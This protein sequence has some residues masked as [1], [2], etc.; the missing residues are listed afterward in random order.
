MGRIISLPQLNETTATAEHGV[1]QGFAKAASAITY[2]L[3]VFAKVGTG[4]T[5]ICL[6]AYSNGAPSLGAGIYAPFDL[7]GGQAGTISNRGAG[8]AGSTSS[9]V[10]VGNGFY[11]C[12]VTFTTETA[13]DLVTVVLSDNGSGTATQSTNFAGT[14]NNGCY[15]Y[16]AQVE[17]GSFPT[18]YIQTFASTVTRAA[19]NISLAN[20][21]Y[22]WSANTCTLY[23]EG[24][25]TK[26]TGIVTSVVSDGNISLGREVSAGQSRIVNRLTSGFLSGTTNI[27]DGVSFKIAA[28]VDVG[29]NASNAAVNGTLQGAFTNPAN[30][31]TTLY[32][33]DANSGAGLS[34]V[35]KTIKK[36]MLLPR[37]MTNAELQTL[38]T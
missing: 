26:R 31:G 6:M 38:T 22:P 21:A 16:G 25:D 28:G 1:T 17:P 11:R 18:S 3:S 9:I 32:L 4:R 36:I 33:G 12:S 15:I 10:A 23:Y 35:S 5:R 29:A 2:T 34:N 27:A 7:S 37:R 20:T 14:V 8:W 19:D 24:T 13:T 30:A